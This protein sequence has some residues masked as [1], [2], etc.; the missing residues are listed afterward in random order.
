M[1]IN[2]KCAENEA[3]FSLSGTRRRRHGALSE[4]YHGLNWLRLQASRM[5]IAV[6]MDV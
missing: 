3:G 2:E 6:I 5:A 1:E 4:R